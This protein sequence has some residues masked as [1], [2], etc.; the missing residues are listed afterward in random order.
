MKY[1][2]HYDSPLG[3]ITLA[4]DGEALTGLWFDGQ[5]F[6]ADTL[7]AHCED[8]TSLPVLAETR[9]WL[10][11]YFSGRIPSFVPSLRF[12]CT[13]FRRRVWEVLLTI[14]YGRTVSYGDIARQV[15]KQ[16]GLACMSAQAC[17]RVV[18]SDG[19]LTGYAGGMERKQALLQLERGGLI[20]CGRQ[21]TFLQE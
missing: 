19:S 18:G 16:M 15:A 9:R 6:F 4:S 2:A 10:D 20:S 13:E 1:T 3:G 21:G 8:C 12:E 17:H 14:P 7:G 11:I 5:K